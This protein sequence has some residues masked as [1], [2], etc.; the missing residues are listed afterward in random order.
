MCD[1]AA[2]DYATLPP[3]NKAFLSAVQ[4]EIHTSTPL[5]ATV[6][7]N[8]SVRFPIPDSQLALDPLSITLSCDL[9]I[10]KSDGQ[11]YTEDHRLFVICNILHSMLNKVEIW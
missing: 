1:N 6:T 8:L 11:K 2:L 5:P 10:V 4:E 7:N 3:V 9:R